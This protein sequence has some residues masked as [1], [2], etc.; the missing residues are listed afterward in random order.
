MVFGLPSES[1]NKDTRD[2]GQ[3]VAQDYAQSQF[4][5]NRGA[6][7]N[8]QVSG[9]GSDLLNQQQQGYS[10]SD[11]ANAYRQQSQ[12]R[13][14]NV[15]SNPYQDSSV[16]LT[17]NDSYSYN[18][19]PEQRSYQGGTDFEG[20][21]QD[22]SR[23]GRN[24]QSNLSS[25]TGMG[26]TGYQ[27]QGTDKYGTGNRGY[28]SN[29]E[30]KTAGYDDSTQ[31]AGHSQGI[32]GVSGSDRYDTTGS[33]TGFSSATGSDTRGTGWQRSPYE[34]QQQQT[35]DYDYDSYDKSTNRTGFQQQQPQSGVGY[36][37]SSGDDY[38]QQTQPLSSQDYGGANVDSSRYDYNTSQGRY[39][40]NQGI[41][42]TQS[43]KYDT[44][45]QGYSATDEAAQQGRRP[46][47]GEKLKGVAMQATG[48]L[49]GDT[50]QKMAGEHLRKFGE[51]T[52][53]Q[54]GTGPFK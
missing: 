38:Q 10:S 31:R 40:S 42:G 27:A 21:P 14:T 51:N 54:A 26:G 35:G 4:G 12:N 8:Q 28:S 39:G 15:A 48:A 1:I 5:R 47:F 37:P 7:A 25:A 45:G 33:D 29:Y 23:S 53:Q 3:N 44:Q 30:Q 17:G 36:G 2:R 41:G 6:G 11:S 52:G 34:Q 32:S 16:G 9:G 18:R 13:D 43:S 24:L 49:K 20:I 50:Q 19:G 22:T 46:S